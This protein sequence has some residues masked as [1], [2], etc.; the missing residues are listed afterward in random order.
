MHREAVAT[1]IFRKPLDGPEVLLLKRATEPFFEE[2]FP[3]EGGIDPSETPDQAVVRE[4]R[5]ETELTPQE[6]RFDSTRVVPSA[7]AHVR[8]HIYAT[9]VPLDAS[10]VLNAEHSEFRWCTPEQA[11]NLLPLVAQKDALLRL[12]AKFLGNAAT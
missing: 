12:R 6:I 8:I 4:L 1:L 11:H 3:V 2:W 9:I 5:E 10:V 7:P